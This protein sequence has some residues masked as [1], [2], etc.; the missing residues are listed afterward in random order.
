MIK[1][2]LIGLLCLGAG[3]LGWAQMPPQNLGGQVA[4]LREDVRIMVQR[5]GSMALRIEQLERDNTALLAATN[6]MDRTYATVVQ[7]NEAVAELNQAI[8]SG[9]GT[10]RSQLT[11]AVGKLARETNDALD[12]VVKGMVVR[13]AISTP[14]FD[15]NFPKDGLSYTV[16]K[17]DTLSSIASRFNSTVK[18]IQ[19]AN[20]IT[21]PTRIQVGRTLFIP[22]GQ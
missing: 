19:N 1:S 2:A 20:R 11:Q 18:N 15:D 17:G 21:D 13:A 22:G 7:L 5:I 14:K 10:T 16:Q 8:N 4:G 9:D 12:S 6:G 3:S